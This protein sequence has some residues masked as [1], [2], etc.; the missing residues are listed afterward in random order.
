M[1][2]KPI[3]IIGVPLDLGASRRGTDMGPSAI[4]YARLSESI[5]GL[6][7]A[8]R[9]LGN[10]EVPV[11]ET[12]EAGASIKYLD[13]IAAACE[14]LARRVAASL[15]SGNLP[16]V[17]GGDHSIAMGTIAG[18]ALA[19]SEIGVV[20]ID[21]H[22]DFNTPETSPSGNIHGMPLAVSTGRG[23]PRLVEIGRPGAKVRDEHVV[24]VGARSIDPLERELLRAS[25]VTVFTMKEIDERGF[26][27]VMRNAIE[28]A[29]AGGRLGLHVS[30]DLDVIDPHIAPGV[31]TPVPGGITY[32]EAH[33]A[34]ELVAESG[35]A[36]SL[37]FVEVNPILDQGN[38]TAQTAV[39]LIQSALGK[40]IL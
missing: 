18:H 14:E 17:L 22:A 13:E 15:R 8:V 5:A 33:L 29:S 28:I 3:D 19:G 37:E 7:P 40:R 12:R 21:A 4:R 32:R 9:D 11:P 39:E 24:I 26:A 35:L 36:R 6:V 23:H 1:A 27:N 34:L 25:R 31:G 38:R 30:F 10:I 2:T 20:W 16:L